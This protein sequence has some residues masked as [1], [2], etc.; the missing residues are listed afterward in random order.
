MR[1]RS[2]MFEAI[3]RREIG[4][5][6]REENAIG[7]LTTKLSNDSRTVSKATGDTLARQLQAFFTLAVGLGLGLAA[8]WKVALVV[9]ATFPLSIIASAIQ[10]QAIAGQQ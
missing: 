5:F 7:D 3:L 2:D 6:D 8:A 1:L 10:M 9:L 4:F